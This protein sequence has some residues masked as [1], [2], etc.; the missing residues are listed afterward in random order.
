MLSL[1]P[2]LVPSSYCDQLFD[3]LDRVPPFAYADVERIFLE[4]HGKRPTE[5]FDRFDRVPFASASIGQVHRAVLDGRELAVKVRRPTAL[6]DFGGDI[7]LMQALVRLIEVLRLKNLEGFRL[8]LNEF[9]AWTGDE[10]DYRREAR[11]MERI[12]RNT[13]A[14]SRARVPAVIQELSTERILA[15]EFLEGATLLEYLRSLERE[16]P[17][18]ALRLGEIG[19][20]SDTFAE[21]IR[22][23]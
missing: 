22:Q 5:L 3:L 14:S 7:G 21:N 1:Q 13:E 20:D 9:V 6:R 16:D 17:A 18:V 23:N 12:R 10:L 15:A 19:F 11:Y 4:D 2:D 8:P